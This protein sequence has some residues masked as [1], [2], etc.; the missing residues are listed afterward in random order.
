MIP[1]C[2]PHWWSG[3]IYCKPSYL[4]SIT[5]DNSPYLRILFCLFC[6]FI[7]QQ[8]ERYSQWIRHNHKHVSVQ[9]KK[10]HFFHLQRCLKR[11][12]EINPEYMTRLIKWIKG[13]TRIGFFQ[14]RLQAFEQSLVGALTYSAQHKP[15][16]K[17]KNTKPFCNNHSN[18]NFCPFIS[19]TKKYEK[20]VIHNYSKKIICPVCDHQTKCLF[21]H[22]SQAVSNSPLAVQVYLPQQSASDLTTPEDNNRALTSVPGQS[23]INI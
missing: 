14:F 6:S 4:Y 15:P 21:A 16:T 12:F 18:S 20:D 19:E 3:D 1:V 11:V 13:H 7:F 9:R 17:T 10:E 22:A 5:L 8:M 23:Q 2:L